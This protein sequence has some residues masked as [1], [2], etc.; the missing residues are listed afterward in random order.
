MDDLTQEAEEEVPAYSGR[1]GGGFT[2]PVTMPNQDPPL[3]PPGPA[4]LGVA[5]R[6]S[7]LASGP[8]PTA[9]DP[10]Q[11]AGGK[12]AKCGVTEAAARHFDWSGCSVI[13]LDRRFSTG[14]Q[15][16]ATSNVDLGSS[17]EVSAKPQL[18]LGSPNVE[19]LDTA[20]ECVYCSGS[21]PVENPTRGIIL[22][23][24]ELRGIDCDTVERCSI[25]LHGILKAGQSRVLRGE[26]ALP[27]ESYR[28]VVGWIPYLSNSV[29]VP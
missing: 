20:N 11:F 5:E 4:L 19:V 7:T 24:L 3:V 16:A 17:I 13:G 25:D 29:D 26:A 10:H 12:C 2:P 22:V 21:I 9:P 23:K 14:T 15:T 27:I 8:L 1:S 18:I 6:R 28:S